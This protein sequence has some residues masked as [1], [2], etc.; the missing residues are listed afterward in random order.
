VEPLV[1]NKAAGEIKDQYL[2]A[3]TARDRL[4][5]TPTTTIADGLEQTFDWYREFILGAR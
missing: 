1:L 3:S 5:W 4:N 2:N